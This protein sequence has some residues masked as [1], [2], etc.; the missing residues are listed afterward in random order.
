MK[1]EH[2]S[3]TEEEPRAEAPYNFVQ[4]PHK[5]VKARQCLPGH[6]KYD[7]KLCTGYIDCIITTESP[8]YIRCGMTPEFYR[9]NGYKSFDELSE[10]QQKQMA[11]FFFTKDENSPVIPASSIR[12]MTRTLLE[13][14]SYGKVS[15]VTNDKIAYRAVV[16]KS[17]IGSYYM[18]KVKNQKAG[19]MEKKADGWYIRPAQKLANRDFCT[20]RAKDINNIV[21]KLNWKF[22]GKKEYTTSDGKKKFCGVCYIYVGNVAAEG[23]NRITEMS[24]IKEKGYRQAMLIVTG[25][26][27]GKKNHC[28]IGLPDKEAEPIKI[29][30]SVIDA[31]KAQMT[32]WQKD[33][34]GRDGVLVDGYPV[35]YI[36]DGNGDVVMF[37]HTLM[38]RLVYES[39]PFDHIPPEVKDNDVIDLADAIFGYALGKDEKGYAGRVSFTDG[40]LLPG[41]GD[42]WLNGIFS[43][44]ILASPKPSAFQHYLI[45]DKPN[46][47][48]TNRKILNHYDSKDG[49]EIAAAIRG[50]KLYWHKGNVDLTYIK[51]DD[52]DVKDKKTQYTRIKPVRS[53]VKFRSRIYFENLREEEIG[54]LLWVLMLPDSYRHEIGM[55]KPYG[56]GAVKLEPTLYIQDIKKRYEGLFDGDTWLQPICKDEPKKYI[57]AFKKY[58]MDNISAEDANK[59]RDF[60]QLERIKMLLK[61]LEWH[62]PDKDKTSYMS[63]DKFKDRKVLPGPFDIEK[64]DMNSNKKGNRV[65]ASNQERKRNRGNDI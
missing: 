24:A 64:H 27:N 44:H 41:Q 37:G 17:S 45:Q 56:M 65:N 22:G 9:E 58:I 39:T 4:L 1:I 54:G 60:E 23:N 12:G 8:T 3:L 7:D 29:Q 42:I 59:A 57:E 34:I 10:D 55:G 18:E 5:I 51:A 62:G 15:W 25:Y 14:A 50:H 2:R 28:V 61:I 47:K 53:G 48:K 11:S 52:N 32:D 46:D 13:I 38:F 49:N 16:D 36:Q 63:I 26:I 19:Y 6:D 21:S 30:D 20:V 35:F 33:Y 40:V 43:P 31:Y